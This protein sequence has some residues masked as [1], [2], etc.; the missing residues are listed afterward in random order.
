MK[1][2]MR[3]ARL[4][5]QPRLYTLNHPLNHPHNINLLISSCWSNHQNI[6]TKHQR[7][8]GI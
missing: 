4:K 5:T 1:M 8:D 6:S 2:I 7:G 3:T